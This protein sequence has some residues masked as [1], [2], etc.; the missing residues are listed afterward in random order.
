MGDEDLL[1]E[2]ERH[3]SSS[4]VPTQEDDSTETG[5]RITRSQDGRSCHDC[6]RLSRANVELRRLLNSPILVKEARQGRAQSQVT[7][8]K[9]K[10]KLGGVPMMN[11]MVNGPRRR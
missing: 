2:E 10:L 1:K 11:G 6:E 7:R 9:A 4:G 5:G 3:R 8:R